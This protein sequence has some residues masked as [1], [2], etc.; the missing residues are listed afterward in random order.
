MNI[1]SYTPN[2]SSAA[3]PGLPRHGAWTV[4]GEDGADL[5]AFTSFL[6]LSVSSDADAP[7]QPVEQG[8]F[9]SAN[10][11]ASPVEATVTLAVQGDSASFQDVLDTLT[12]FTREARLI[13]VVTP[14]REFADMTLTGF[15]YSRKAGEGLSMLVVDLKIREVSH[16]PP[17][18]ASTDITQDQAKDPGD[19]TAVS[20]GQKRVKYR[21]DLASHAI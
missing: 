11:I 2:A 12:T 8:G 6:G 19:V 5:V 17:R 15:S 13:S 3:A 14:E 9:Y 21:P 18:Y 1:T 16:I 4:S 7:R 20:T 10:K